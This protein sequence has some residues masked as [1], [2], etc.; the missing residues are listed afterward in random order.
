[1]PSKFWRSNKDLS[2][3]RILPGS[4]LEGPWKRRQRGPLHIH[5]PELFAISG[6]PILAVGDSQPSSIARQG[7]IIAFAYRAIGFFYQEHDAVFI[8]LGDLDLVAGLA[9]EVGNVDHRQRIG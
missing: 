5:I 4:R 9:N 3:R 1:M 6:L 2:R 8:A 7:R